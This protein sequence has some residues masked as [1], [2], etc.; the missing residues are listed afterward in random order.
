MKK[1]AVI[2]AP[3]SKYHIC[4][5]IEFLPDFV[6]YIMKDPQHQKEMKLIFCQVLEG[7]RS[8]KYGDEEYGTKAMKPFKNRENDR[9]ICHVL[10]RK[11]SKQCIIMSEIYLQ[12]KS[13][14]VSKL[15]KNRYK[16]VSSY[17]YEIVE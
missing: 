15:L 16:L 4:C 8:K 12:K 7:L 6:E 5:D 10:K 17:E 14:N 13:D 3:G 11:N 9:I 2:L 1:K